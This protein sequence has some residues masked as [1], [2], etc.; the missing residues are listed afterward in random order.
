[1]PTIESP[2]TLSARPSPIASSALVSLPLSLVGDDLTVPLVTGEQV[3]YTNLDCAASAPCLRA[4]DDVLASVLPWYSSVH[5]G[6]GFASVVLSDAYDD[7]REVVAEFLGARSDDA[8]VFT[9]NTTDALNLL[10]SSLPEGTTVVSFVSEHH[11]N[12][13]PW[14]RGTHVQLPVPKSPAHAIALVDAALREVG[15]G[16]CLVAIAGASNVT[17]E[18]WPIEEL[19]TLAH[20]H[21]ARLAVDA[22]QLAPHRAIDMAATGIDYLALSAHKLY[23]PFGAGVLVGRSDWLDA[24]EP[25]LAGGGAVRRVTA[26]STDWASGSARH[27]AGTP[28]VIGAIALAAACREL[29]TVGMRALE[30]HEEVLRR[31]ATRGLSAIPGVEILSMWGPASVRVGIVTFRLR[32]LQPGLLA[33]ALSAEYGIGVRDGSFCAHPLVDAL[34]E[35]AADAR[36]GAVRASFGVGT[37]VT[38]IDRFLAAIETLATHGPRWPYRLVAGRYVPDPDPRPRPSIAGL[39]ARSAREVPRS[40]AEPCRA[41]E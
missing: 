22:A 19:A 40:V 20:W 18:I 11:A 13:L 12:L 34:L 15:S 3:R 8:V 41:L 21:G 35:D 28:N 9:R 10:A 27:E 39:R 30:E 14:R 4:V 2:S 33:S 26:E 32:G 24:A 16:P 37:S 6:A 5:R 25:Y 38:D 1:M 7:A 31:R 29:G 23:A 17:G 36:A